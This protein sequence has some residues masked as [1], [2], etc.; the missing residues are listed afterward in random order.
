[1]GSS[2]NQDICH[3]L[4]YATHAIMVT[5]R[6]AHLKVDSGVK[7]ACGLTSIVGLCL[8]HLEAEDCR[9]V[10]LH[11]QDLQGTK[12]TLSLIPRSISQCWICIECSEGCGL[13]VIFGDTGFG[14]VSAT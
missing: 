3:A 8:S 14:R 2:N 6:T 11:H 10:G 7:L 1:M 12:F 9:G 13:N 4:S 5:L